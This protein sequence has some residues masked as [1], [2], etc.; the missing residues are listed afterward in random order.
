MSLLEH[1][2]VRARRLFEEDGVS[3]IRGMTGNYTRIWLDGRT[4]NRRGGFRAADNSVRALCD[5]SGGALR[6]LS[7]I[8]RFAIVAPQGSRWLGRQGDLFILKGPLPVDYGLVLPDHCPCGR[9]ARL[10]RVGLDEVRPL[11]ALELL[12]RVPVGRAR[13]RGKK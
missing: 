9:H 13:G 8:G 5:I 11:T 12:A 1:T 7:R 2:L 3:V 10:I 6:A 4:T